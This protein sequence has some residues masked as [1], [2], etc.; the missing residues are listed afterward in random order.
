MT[1]RPAPISIAEHT[2]RRQLAI[3]SDTNEP[4]KSK[5]LWKRSIHSWFEVLSRS[6]GARSSVGLSVSL[7]A[8]RSSHSAVAV[9]WN[10]YPP[11]LSHPRKCA[12]DSFGAEALITGV[13]EMR[14]AEPFAPVR[15]A[16]TNKLKNML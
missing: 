11:C 15:S 1:S 6:C 10:C 5:P 16:E 14:R 12:F 9:F 7:P 3:T 13:M 2:A 8:G 4:R